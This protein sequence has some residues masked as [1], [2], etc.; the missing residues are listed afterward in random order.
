MNQF[1]NA[2][3]QMP[4]SSTENGAATFSSSLD[5]HVDLFFRVGASRG[6]AAE[7]VRLFKKALA[8]NQDLAIRVALWARDARGGAGE[9]E[10]FREMLKVMPPEVQLALIPKIVELGRWD[11]LG[12]LV[13]SNY[14]NV[15]VKAAFHWHDAIMNGNG[16]AA[17]WCPRIVS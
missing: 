6:K 9:R 1:V 17:K 3:I 10:I 5:T 14:G 15:V 4:D 2:A 11:D 12:V 8:E 13:E 7:V 16:L